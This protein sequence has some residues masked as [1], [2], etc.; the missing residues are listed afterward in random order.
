[1]RIARKGGEF[2]VE[3]LIKNHDPG[4][5]GIYS[6]HKYVLKDIFRRCEG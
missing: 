3:R 6:I 2:G 1:L 5:L 4:H